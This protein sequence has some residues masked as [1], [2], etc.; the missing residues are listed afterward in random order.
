MKERKKGCG[1]KWEGKWEG[2]E[3]SWEGETVITIYC[4]KIFTFKLKKKVLTQPR[5]VLNLLYSWRRMTLDT[6]YSCIQFSSAKIP[7]MS[8]RGWLA[9][10]WIEC[11][12][13]FIMCARHTF[14]QLSCIPSPINILKFDSFMEHQLTEFWFSAATLSCAGDGSSD[15][16]R[17]SL[18]VFNP[19]ISVFLLPWPA[20][21]RVT[22]VQTHV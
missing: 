13:L 1:F 9:W 3:R 16:G 7:C 4:I 6:W 17:S 18:T 8:H 15:H 5:L 19:P 21:K 10:C 11:R 14:H 12:V 2:P 20:A 22:G